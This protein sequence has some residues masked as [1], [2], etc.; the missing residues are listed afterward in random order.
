MAGVRQL[1]IIALTA[2]V[3]GLIF[4]LHKVG[5]NAASL[6]HA[7]ASDQQPNKHNTKSTTYTATND[8]S[9]ANLIDSKNDPQTDDKINQKISKDQDEAI[10]GNKDTTKV[11]PDNGEYDPISDLIKIRSL[12]PMTIFSKSYCPYSKKIKQLLLEK[13]DITPAPNVVELDRYEYGAELQSYL[14][15]KSGRRTVPN[16]LVG[17]SFESRGGCDEFEKLHKDN[18]LIKLLV[19]WGSGRLQVAKKNTPSNA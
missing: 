12:S 10:N 2:F 15:E 8:E 1:R 6:V 19:E 17:K 4:T 9:V 11:K 3:L 13:Y 5:S 7:Q 14:T 16:V 18:D